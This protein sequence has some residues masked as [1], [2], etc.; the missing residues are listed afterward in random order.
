[1][2]Q[3]SA[4]THSLFHVKAFP[5][6]AHLYQ[7]ETNQHAYANN[8]MAGLC[9]FEYIVEGLLDESEDRYFQ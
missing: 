2:I 3:R 5:V 4:G 9:M 1:M 7:E 8:N 6:V